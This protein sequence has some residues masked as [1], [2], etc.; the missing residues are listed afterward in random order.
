MAP[1]YVVGRVGFL[2]LAFYD[3]T[4]RRVS[5]RTTGKLNRRKMRTEET[6]VDEKRRDSE[7][8]EVI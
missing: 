1:P 3:E 2:F 5:G 7:Y 8:L 6:C 4:Q